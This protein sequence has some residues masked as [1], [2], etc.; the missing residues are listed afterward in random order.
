M[1]PSRFSDQAND[2]RFANEGSYPR[3]SDYSV[4]SGGDPFRSDVLSPS[5]QR[6]VGSPFSETSRDFSSEIQGHQTDLQN[7]QSFKSV[8]SMKLQEVASQSEQSAETSHAKTS[9]VPSPP[10]SSAA[11][12]FQGLDLFDAP[13][14][15]QNA[16]SSNSKLPES[17]LD[18]SVDLFQQSP[19][20]SVPTFNEQRPPQTREP[21]AL[22]LFTVVSQLQP[23]ASSNG[24]TSD[25]VTPSNGGWATF[26]MPQNM[27]PVGSENSATAAV[28]SSGGN[29]IGNFNPFSLDQ[30]SFH[31]NSVSH[32]ASVSTHA[33][34]HDSLQNV[35]TAT[36]NTQ[37]S[38]VLDELP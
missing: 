3:A 8:N 26:D 4:S 20:S 19:I 13:F 16:T 36:N 6:D 14:A 29:I 11:T 9:S 24:K 38:S 18:N 33:F 1:S 15:P 23:G 34:W 2:D 22:D 30:S 10:Q 27:V 17:S 21:S 25:V 28:S 32:E 37:V 35:E 12:S 7:L 31:Q 5:S